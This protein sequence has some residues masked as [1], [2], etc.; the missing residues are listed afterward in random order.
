MSSHPIHRGHLQPRGDGEDLFRYFRDIEKLPWYDDGPD[1]QD[2]L[3]IDRLSR[4]E[5]S[6]LQVAAGFVE[7]TGLIPE[8]YDTQTPSPLDPPDDWFAP[9]AAQN[10]KPRRHR[11]KTPLARHMD[12]IGM[13]TKELADKAGVGNHMVWQVMHFGV[14]TMR[15]AKKYLDA[16]DP[17]R[18]VLHE[19]HLMRPKAYPSNRPLNMFPVEQ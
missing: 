1:A 2:L 10:G 14:R 12:A 13:T 3:L 6:A 8:H 5:V 17:K 4:G 19:L 16:I 11:A 15:A 18:E 9:R 7:V